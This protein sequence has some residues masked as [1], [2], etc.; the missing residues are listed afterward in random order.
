MHIDV[1]WKGFLPNMTSINNLALL[2]SVLFGLIG[3]EMSAVHAGEVKNPQRDYPRALFISAVLIIVTL[4][5]GSLAIAMVVPAGQLDLASGLME[6]FSIFFNAYHITWMVPVIAILIILGGFG[7]VSAWVIGPTKGMMVAAIDKNAPAYLTR[8]NQYGVPVNV[9]LTQG[10]VFTIL[11]T[12]F[13]FMPS[14][15]SAFGLLSQMTGEVALIVYMLIFAAAIRL[16]YKRPDVARKFRVPGG[17]AG[18]WIIAGAGILISSVVFI[19]GLFPPSQINV[20]SVAV[21]EA[22][23]IGGTIVICLPAFLWHRSKGNS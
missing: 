1:S 18:M 9:L 4:T 12:L 10:I 15:N 6:S 17:N 7:T 3:L 23:L 14:I 22:I 19:I 16:R 2:S 5:L 13:I 8:R 20:G 21:Y 11:S